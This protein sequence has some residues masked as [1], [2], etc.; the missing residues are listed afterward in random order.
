MHE[1]LESQG[2][3]LSDL[4]AHVDAT[5]LRLKGVRKRVAEVT[6]AVAAD[7]QLRMICVLSVILA[8]LVITAFI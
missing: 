4:D 5:Q 2:L 1:E 8:I 6:R 3:L 7:G